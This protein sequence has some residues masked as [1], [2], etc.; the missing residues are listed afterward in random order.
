MSWE[1]NKS[2][3]SDEDSK[4]EGASFYDEYNR[5]KH[6]ELFWTVKHQITNHMSKNIHTLVIKSMN[7]ELVCWVSKSK[8]KL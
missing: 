1:K 8:D 6:V 2:E 4:L 5:Q 7:S 3:R